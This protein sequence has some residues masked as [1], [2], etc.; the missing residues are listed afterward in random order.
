MYEGVKLK[1]LPTAFNK[2]LYRGSLIDKKEIIKIKNY[3]N[4]RIPDLPGAI[5]FCKPFLSFSKERYIA[6]EFLLDSKNDNNLAKVIF[7]LEKNCSLDYNSSTHCDL[8][9]ISRYPLEKEVLFFPFS[10]FEIKEI[11]EKISKI[12]ETIYEI[13]LLYL[14]KY[15]KV[16]EEDK[17]IILNENKIPESEF[18]K[19]II[20]FGLIEKEQLEKKINQFYENKD[21]ECSIKMYKSNESEQKNKNNDNEKLKNFEKNKQI[22][23]G[24]TTL[25]NLENESLHCLIKNLNDKNNK[26]ID[27]DCLKNNN[28]N[29]ILN[30]NILNK[31]LNSFKN[32]EE[33][34]IIDEYQKNELNY[35]KNDIYSLKYINK[36]FLKINEKSG[37]KNE[38]NDSPLSENNFGN[39]TNIDDSI[40]QEQIYENKN[41]DAIYKNQKVLDEKLKNEQ[42]NNGKDIQLLKNNENK[43]IIPENKNKQ[44]FVQDIEKNK[45]IISKINKEENNLQKDLEKIVFKNKI[46]I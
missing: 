5:V 12:D 11:K 29:N 19:E 31:D 46:I 1:S 6:E 28:E 14:G 34:K 3:L 27:I 17:N 15:L 24:I 43:N 45:Y 23:E 16:L 13:K 7:I 8:E 35:E 40:K 42:I 37:N 39:Y 22:E 2:V 4:K 44:N 18:K 41:N 21:R 10:S 30:E 36:E 38:M 25:Q 33:N 26:N 20:E 9:K 32:K